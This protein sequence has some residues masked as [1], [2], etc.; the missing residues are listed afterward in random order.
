MAQ[1]DSRGRLLWGAWEQVCFSCDTFGRIS[2]LT[3]ADSRDWPRVMRLKCP[4]TWPEMGLF[5]KPSQTRQNPLQYC[6]YSRQ[7]QWNP[8][9]N[10]PFYERF[11]KRISVVRHTGCGPWRA[12]NSPWGFVISLLRHFRTRAS[13]LARKGLPECW[14]GRSRRESLLRCQGMVHLVGRDFLNISS[15]SVN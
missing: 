10:R 15:C 6:R 12:G 13:N 14:Q 9:S 11:E 4:S 5:S 1:L 2:Y 8:F 7:T 3:Q